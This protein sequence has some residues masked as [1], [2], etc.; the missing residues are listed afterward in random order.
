MYPKAQFIQ[1]V[2]SFE[3]TGLG[4]PAPLAGAGYKVPPDKRAQIMY[5]RAG[6]ST[7]ALVC[8][9]LRCDGKVMRLFPVGAKQSVH[10]Q[11]VMTEDV[12]PESQLD[13]VIA[14]PKGVAGLV[15][16]DLGLFEI[17]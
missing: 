9:T 16:V 10:V 15:V 7:D 5:L 11:L 4:N 2:F 6:N 12:F 8:I 17:A 1:G 13:L 14:A 3:G